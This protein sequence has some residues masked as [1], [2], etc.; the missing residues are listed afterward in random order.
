MP[1]LQRARPEV[2]GDDVGGDGETLDERLALGGAQVAGDGLLVPRLDQPEVRRPVGGGAAQA[3]EIVT[4][5]R[6][7]DLDHVGAELAQQRAA[8]GCGH[9]GGK[10]QRGEALER[11]RHGA[12]IV[13]R[14]AWPSGRRVQP[15][16]GRG[17]RGECCTE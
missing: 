4:R 12:G 16:G 13:A 17:A 3:A 1:A 15:G 9:E 6:L 11:S 8:E 5:A 14:A 10:V 2:L 7:L